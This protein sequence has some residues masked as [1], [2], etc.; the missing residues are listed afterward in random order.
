MEKNEM[1]REMYAN[2]LATINGGVINA[3]IGGI[4]LVAALITLGYQVGADRAEIDNK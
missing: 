1:M 4:T 2:E 3:I